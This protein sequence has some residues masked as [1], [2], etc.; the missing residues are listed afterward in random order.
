MNQEILNF[1]TRYLT[2]NRTKDL[3]PSFL[4]RSYWFTLELTGK[5]KKLLA[6]TK[7]LIVEG[8]NQIKYQETENLMTQEPKPG[9]LFLVV[10]WLRPYNFGFGRTLG[11]CPI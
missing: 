11:G 7:K 9:T 10:S 6:W 5:T 3:R 1:G 2:R 8:R 4:V